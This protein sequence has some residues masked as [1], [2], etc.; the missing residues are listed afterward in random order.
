MRDRARQ[1]VFRRLRT[2]GIADLEEHIKFDINF[3]PL[4]WRKRYNLV[5]GATHGL[6]HN[7]TQLAIFRPD[8]GHAKYHNLYFAGASTRPGTGLPNA[9]ISGRQAAQRILDDL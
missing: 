6:C 9:M 7:L 5:K 2:L 3:T 4:S 8:L 1:E